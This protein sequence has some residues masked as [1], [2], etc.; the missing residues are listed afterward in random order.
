VPKVFDRIVARALA[1]DP[2]ARFQ[3]AAELL[4]ALFA[5]LPGSPSREPMQTLIGDMM[6]MELDAS[7]GDVAKLIETP[8]PDTEIST[9]RTLIY[10]QR[11]EVQRSAK[12]EYAPTLVR[13][14]SIRK[15]PSISISRATFFATLS[16]MFALGVVVAVLVGVTS[17]S[18]PPIEPIEVEVPRVDRSPTPQV[19]ERP[20]PEVELAPDEDPRPPRKPAHTTRA[21]GV[22]ET[23]PPVVRPKEP[24]GAG[25]LE[26]LLARARALGGRLP[27]G[28]A[29]AKAARQLVIDVNTE[30]AAEPHDP[31][32]VRSL[33]E[34]LEGLE[35]L[36]EK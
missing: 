20:P 11:P 1:H 6:W 17:R 33:R 18:A 36:D 15:P 4:S 19:T 21:A 32:R 31:A 25:D 16:G 12:S 26:A 28:S 13:A 29:E 9:H 30:L 27:K 23:A 10:A 34:R 5:A 3:S 8:V 24:S 7:S 35:G 22:E 14:V 2:E